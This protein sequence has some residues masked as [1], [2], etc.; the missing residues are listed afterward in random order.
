MS[1]K[2]NC[3]A[4]PCA[5]SAAIDFTS[6]ILKKLSIDSIVV[7]ALTFRVDVSDVAAG[8]RFIL[9]RSVWAESSTAMGS[10]VIIAVRLNRSNRTVNGTRCKPR[11]IVTRSANP[12]VSTG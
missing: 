7:D 12:F 6:E 9:I 2:I 8:M 4:L 3:W 10:V 1:I 5:S 11:L